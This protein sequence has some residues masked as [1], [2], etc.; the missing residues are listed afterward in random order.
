MEDKPPAMPHFAP[1]AEVEIREVDEAAPEWG[2][3]AQEIAREAGLGGYAAEGEADER[4]GATA[5]DEV[6]G[7]R[8]SQ[9]RTDWVLAVVVTMWLVHMAVH[10]FGGH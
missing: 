9:R 2:P 5:F 8:R 7:L 1:P 3:D 4:L 10:F 6:A